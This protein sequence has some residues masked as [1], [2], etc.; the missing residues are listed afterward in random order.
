MMER[1]DAVPVG[2]GGVRTGIDESAHGRD[3]IRT[4]VTEYHGLH[5]CRPTE[6]VDVIERCAAVDQ[7]TDDFMVAQ[8]GGRDEGR[9]LIGAGDQIGAVSEF[10]RERHHFGIVRDRGDGQHV[11]DPVLEPIHV[12]AGF[13]KRAKGIIVRGESGHMRGGA[14]GAVPRVRI[15]ARRREPPNE[16]DVP[17]MRGAVQPVVHR[18]LGRGRCGL[19][20]SFAATI[21]GPMASAI[22]DPRVD[23]T[24]AEVLRP[25]A[26]VLLATDALGIS[27]FDTMAIKANPRP[28]PAES[29]AIARA[30]VLAAVWM[31]ETGAFEALRAGMY[32][33]HTP[34][35]EGPIRAERIKPAFDLVRRPGACGTAK[36][37]RTLVDI[38][39][40]VPP[41]DLTP[42][43]R[44]VT[45]TRKS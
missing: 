7:S 18:D 34:G 9:S 3:M 5:Q 13:G 14:S 23:M 4:A 6:V 41:V 16:F 22:V 24:A 43:V 37:R 2:N 30:S 33:M 32:E 11:V 42:A 17:F 1:G 45:V 40:N 38:A 20:Y 21:A 31:R 29:V 25:G 39:K 15:G 44:P 27:R 28:D 35:L 36:R 12:G 10:N 8:V 19:S 26:A